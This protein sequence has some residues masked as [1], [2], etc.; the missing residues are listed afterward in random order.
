MGG[1]AG[2]QDQGGNEP[3]THQGRLQP[4]KGAPPF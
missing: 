1:R 3:G 4:W 2:K